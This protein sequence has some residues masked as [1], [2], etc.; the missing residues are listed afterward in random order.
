MKISYKWLLEYL[1]KN[2]PVVIQ[3]SPEKVSTI[4][5]SVGLEVEGMEKFEE[6]KGGLDGLIVG[7]V[8]ECEKHPD[9]DKLK[10]TKVDVGNA[11]FLQIVCGAPNV[12]VNQKVVVAMVGATLHPESGDSFKIKK[13]KIR[14]VESNGMLCAEDE[15]GI[16]KSHDG[17]IV[18]PDEAIV[19]TTIKDFYGLYEDVIFEI[20]LTPNRMDAMSHIGVAKDVCAYLSHVHKTDI[21]VV[22]PDKNSFQPGENAN[23]NLEVDASIC[24][25]YAG[26]SFSG[27]KVA[28]SPK[29]IQNKLKSIGQKPVNNI[30]DITNFILHETGQPLHAFDMDKISGNEI[31]VKTLPAGTIFKSLDGKE[32]KLN[33]EEIMICDAQNTPL[34]MGGIYGGEESGVSED[35]TN[36][37][38]ESAVFDP[39]KIRKAL[40]F[41]DLR[42]DAAVRFEK[43]VDISKTVDVLKRATVLIHEIAG[44][45]ISSPIVDIYPEVREHNEV[46][47]SFHYLKKLSGKN[48]HP[49]TVKKILRSLNFSILRESID[50]I[51]VAVPFSNPDITLPVDVVEEIMRIDGLD[52]I[53]IPATVKTTPSVEVKLEETLRGLRVESY[54]IGLGF[55]EIFT[56]SITNSDY[57]DEATL[58][59]SVKIINGLSVDL[60][61]MRPS[62]VPT[63]L[64]SIAHNINRKNKNLMFYDFGKIYGKSETGYQETDKMSLFITGEI[65]EA[66]WNETKKVADIYYL[67][68]ILSSLMQLLGEQKFKWN[69]REDYWLDNAITLNVNEVE[70]AFIGKIKKK[71][72]S[73][74]SIKQEVYYLC[75]DWTNAMQLANNKKTKFKPLVKFPPVSRDLSLLLEKNISYQQIEEAVDS[76]K[77]KKLTSVALFDVFENEKLGPNKKS[78]ALSFTFT[79]PEKTLVDKETDNMMKQIITVLENKLNAVIRSHA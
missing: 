48:Y 14:G 21:K 44:G 30:V 76:L 56:N 12:A 59:N 15:I 67:K 54:L 31:R 35:T 50:E 7:Q 23:L 52:N 55:S 40:L 57:F 8:I 47:L 64:E 38:L 2:D 33:G 41:H 4:L 17:I 19:G 37:F 74:F 73:D 70:I 65:K 43:G 39:G 1:P 61:V 24:N 75:M 62:M 72:L 68:G 25:R 77:I 60:D 28:P 66:A 63:G 18:L 71:H 45:E 42:T 58:K 6:V 22:Q 26:I 3:L 20:G 36:L 79:D 11:D 46:T 16:G 32:R 13:S 51:R 5:T 49:D 10:V 78:M 53:E 9:A 27:I 69:E 29:W 34:C